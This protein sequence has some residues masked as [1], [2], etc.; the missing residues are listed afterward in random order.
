MEEAFDTYPKMGIRGFK[1]DYMDCDDQPMV[2]VYYRIA[3]LTEE[4]YYDRFLWCL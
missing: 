2:A 1:I 3:E 4:S